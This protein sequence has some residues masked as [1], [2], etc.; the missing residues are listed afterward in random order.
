MRLRVGRR[1]WRPAAALVVA[2]VL[3]AAQQ[4]RSPGALRWQ[5]VGLA[6]GGT[7]AY[8]SWRRGERDLA[9]ASAHVAAAASRAELAGQNSVAMGAD[10]IID[11]LARTAPLLALRGDGPV[12]SPLFA[13][14][15]KLAAASSREATYLAVALTRWQRR[16][17]GASPDLTADVELLPLDGAGTVLISPTQAERLEQ[18]L[19]RLDLR[20]TASVRVR[21]LLPAG[22]SQVLFVGRHRVTLPADR[23]PTVGA[24]RPGPLGLL[25]VIVVAGGVLASSAAVRPGLAVPVVAVGSGLLV[26][27]NWAV[28]RSVTRARAHAEQRYAATLDEAYQ[29]GRRAVVELADRVAN[30]T[31]KSYERVKPGLPGTVAAEI[32]RRLTDASTRQAALVGAISNSTDHRALLHPVHIQRH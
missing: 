28:L 30:E 29:R 11:L 8:R 12:A 2:A 7:L 1:G 4:P 31:R 26:W 10:S 23:V 18:E 20:G 19:D 9:R 5:L 14:K 22:A 15:A 25:A 6:S 32:E 21:D 27:A 17:N 16:H 13:W 3:V 24:A